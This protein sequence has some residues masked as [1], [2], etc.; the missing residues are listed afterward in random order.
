MLTSSTLAIEDLGPRTKDGLGQAGEDRAMAGGKMG[1]CR[2]EGSLG[3]G[4]CKLCIK[5]GILEFRFG[6][7]RAVDI[8]VTARRKEVLLTSCA[9]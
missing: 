2:R 6:G 7:E 9:L 5:T 4:S 8:I 1:E 3:Y